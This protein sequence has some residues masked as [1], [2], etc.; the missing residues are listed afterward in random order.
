[1]TEY[2]PLDAHRLGVQV[3]V[4]GPRDSYDFNLT[5]DTGSEF[6]VVSA[7]YLRRLGVDVSR[8]WGGRDCEQ[9]PG[10]PAPRW[11]AC[12]PC[13]RSGACVRNRWLRPTT[14]PSEFKPMACWASTSSAPSFCG[15]TSRAGASPSTRRSAGGT[16]GARR[17]ALRQQFAAH[18]ATSADG[19]GAT[20]AV[21]DFCRGVDAEHVEQRRDH[22]LW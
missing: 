21:V 16:S 8:R 4:V 18:A 6:T 5:L 3:T 15:S 9:Q 12:R 1:M 11:C 20:E 10:S 7:M 22:V 19:V 13:P 2:F 17:D 14:T